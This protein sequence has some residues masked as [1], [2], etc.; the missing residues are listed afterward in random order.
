MSKK[1]L[2]PPNPP[3]LRKEFM[4]F[5]SGLVPIHLFITQIKPSDGNSQ[6]LHPPIH[7]Y[8]I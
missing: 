5:T 6:T 3:T 4:V 2:H 7:A 8:L 1:I